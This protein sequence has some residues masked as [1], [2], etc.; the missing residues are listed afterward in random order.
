MVEKLAYV[1]PPPDALFGWQGSAFVFS[2]GG[3]IGSLAAGVVTWHTDAADAGKSDWTPRRGGGGELAVYR[4]RPRLEQISAF[5][6]RERRLTERGSSHAWGFQFADN[7]DWLAVCEGDE[8]QL[9]EKER[10]LWTQRAATRFD[11]GPLIAG[12]K[13]VAGEE[14]GVLHAFALQRSKQAL[15]SVPL[16][17]RL[18]GPLWH[19]PGSPDLIMAASLGGKLSAVSAADGRILWRAELE[20]RMTGEPVAVAGAVAV[21]AGA[22]GVM[23][24]DRATGSLK[25]R[26]KPELPLKHFVSAGA[27]APRLACSDL[28]G[29]ISFLSGLDLHP[30]RSMR[31]DGLACLVGMTNALPATPEGASFGLSPELVVAADRAGV[32]YFMP[33]EQLADSDVKP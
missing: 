12:D 22:G 19:L 20:D 27:S 28:A 4:Y 33:A 17:Q 16:E 7:A 8:L 23:L 6:Q 26:W 25:G 9:V 5:G 1:H 18:F 3:R 10:L 13:V 14:N 21:A 31:I 24:L 30:F 11:C 29:N 2:A 32:I 15:W